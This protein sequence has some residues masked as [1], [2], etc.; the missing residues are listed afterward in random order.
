MDGPRAIGDDHLSVLIIS[1]P[2]HANEES[3]T[4]VYDL[5]MGA[6]HFTGDGT[7]LHQSTHEVLAILASDRSNEELLQEL[8][9]AGGVGMLRAQ[10][11]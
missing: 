9:L 5:L 10:T 8:R 2:R 11:P 7:S 1:T 6:P 4:G 3:E